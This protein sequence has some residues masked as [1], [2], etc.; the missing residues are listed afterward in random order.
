MRF[1]IVLI[2]VLSSAA[3]VFASTPCNPGDIACAARD[4]AL[5]DISA[6]LP[7]AA[8]TGDNGDTTTKPNTISNFLADLLAGKRTEKDGVV[9]LT[10]NL[11]VPAL[12]PNTKKH[13]LTVQAIFTPPALSKDVTDRTSGTAGAADTL[14]K[15]LTELDDVTV[16]V[17]YTYP[18]PDPKAAADRFSELLSNILGKEASAMDQ[19]TY[20]VAAEPLRRLVIAEETTKQSINTSVSH[21]HRRVL[22]GPDET[23]FKLAY[24]VPL[25]KPTVTLK[26]LL[27]SWTK[28]PSEQELKDP[29]EQK[30]TK[31]RRF[32]T[33]LNDVAKT[34]PSRRY[35]LSF[36]LTYKQITRN[37]VDLSH[38]GVTVPNPL[39][40]RVGS[41]SLASE[42]AWG[43]DAY[44]PS[45]THV[46][47]I[48]LS[49]KYDNV[50][51][52]PKRH[53][54]LTATLKFAQKISDNASFPL[55]LIYANHA[56]DLTNVNRRLN[57]HFGISFLLPQGKATTSGPY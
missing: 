28:E 23:S 50:S 39:I 21:R 33:F 5:F 7:S 55:S 56:D 31:E 36:S 42:A 51:N 20:L 17:M 9:T 30:L 52:D 49:A 41:H 22:V 53:D 35:A 2:T 12:E 27:T 29:K 19:R 11:A 25:A 13:P 26:G 34:P 3:T 16:G 46:G 32:D 4:Q 45:S 48:E 43:F 15:N 57:V 40:S 18:Q 8:A 10:W 24:N 54:R 37:D 44:N 1:S 38:A 47:R 6:S 14:K